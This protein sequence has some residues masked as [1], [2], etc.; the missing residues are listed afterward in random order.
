MTTRPRV[1]PLAVLFLPRS[2]AD[3]LVEALA[4]RPEKVGGM[5]FEKYVVVTA[6]ARTYDGLA[7]DAIECARSAFGALRSLETGRVVVPDGRPLVAV[8]DSEV[9]EAAAD[10]GRA[11]RWTAVFKVG[12]ERRI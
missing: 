5:R 12:I 3:E 6:R 11:G 4:S 8:L 7:D 9:T 1:H 2:L 10:G